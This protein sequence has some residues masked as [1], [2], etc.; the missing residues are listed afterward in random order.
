[1]YRQTGRHHEARKALSTAIEM[2]RDMEMALW[3]PE[4]EAALAGLSTAP[5]SAEHVG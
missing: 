3:L 1:V 2:L 4:A 5:A